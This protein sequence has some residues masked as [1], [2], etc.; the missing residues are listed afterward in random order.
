MMTMPLCSGNGTR[1]RRVE[2]RSLGGIG[3]GNGEGEAEHE[4]VEDGEP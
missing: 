1:S 2:R 3:C 4:E